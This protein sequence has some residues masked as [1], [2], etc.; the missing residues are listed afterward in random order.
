[1]PDRQQLIAIPTHGLI[2]RFT[3][4]GLTHLTG[5]NLATGLLD[6]CKRCHPTGPK[7]PARHINL[8]TEQLGFGAVEAR[9]ILLVD[10]T[11]RTFSQQQ[12]LIVQD[13]TGGA[14]QG[15]GRSTVA[16]HAATQQQWQRGLAKQLLRQNVAG[17]LTDPGAGFVALGNQP[18]NRVL[19]LFDHSRVGNFGQNLMLRLILP[20]SPRQR[21]HAR[22]IAVQNQRQRTL[23]ERSQQFAYTAQITGG[24]A[25]THACLLRLARGCAHERSKIVA[26]LRCIAREFQ[27]QHT[28]RTGPR[29]R[30]GQPR[31]SGISR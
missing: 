31:V 9:N 18:I 29:S 2:E 14:H 16:P 15:A 30:H 23:V 21:C 11:Q 27:V 19:H 25:Q 12:H 24:Q 6:A 8:L 22:G 7:N 20:Q 13:H 3:P 1:M 10:V 28:N 4:I 26:Q 5:L 17:V